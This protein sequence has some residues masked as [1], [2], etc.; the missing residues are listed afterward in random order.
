MPIIR[1]P[2]GVNVRFDDDMPKEQIQS[3]IESKYP[4]FAKSMGYNQNTKEKLQIQPL[5][6][7]KKE[8]IRQEVEGKRGLS[9]YAPIAEDALTGTLEGVNYGLGKLASGLTLGLS[10]KID[11]VKQEP[12][13]SEAPKTAEAIGTGLEFLGSLPTSAGIYSGVKN[14]PRL[15]KFALPIAGAVESGLT[16]LIKTGDIEQAG[17]SAGLGGAI[18]T[19]LKGIGK[20]AKLV[21]DALG[22][23]SGA[24][25]SS[26]RQAVEAGKRSSKPF[27]ESMR[28][29]AEATNGIINIAENDFKQLGKQNYQQYKTAMEKIGGVENIEF[30]PIK[31]TLKRIV[32]EEAGGKTY[33]VDKETQKVISQTADMLSEFEKDTRKSLKDFDDLKRAIG[34]ISVPMEAKN[35]QRVQ[36]ELY[37][38]VK[39]EI[40]KQA[41]VYSD[42]MRES[43]EGLE[44]LG[45]LKKTFSLGR[46]SSGDTVL[47]K[48]QS[49]SRNNVLTNY[50]RREELLKQLPHGEELADRI[51][52]QTLNAIMPRGLEARGAALFGGGASLGGIFNPSY[53]LASSPRLVGEM[54][55]KAGQAS[56]YARPELGLS[57]LFT[58]IKEKE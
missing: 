2:D 21:P 15:A 32:S 58:A 42:I 29:G 47:R 37:N 34:N 12:N 28:K 54:A 38:A 51:A 11:P 45:E 23:T 18:G 50:G 4:D 19:A 27:L 41:P 57:G 16:D 6:D 56:R 17:K 48:L 5:S 55:Y 10:E 31:D 14:A 25:G 35:A 40:G 33:L 44:K 52:G 9:D 8:Q 36:T 49:S 39:G 46:K 3:M 20:V 43:A 22:L 24:G 13:F 53:L 7:E 26:I 1:M 30:K